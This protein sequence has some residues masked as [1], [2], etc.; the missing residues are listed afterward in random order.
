MTDTTNTNGA[1]SAAA[2]Q[3]L[4]P[5]QARQYELR[6]QIS[7]DTT[8]RAIVPRSLAEVQAFAS[9]M[10]NSSLVPTALRERAADVAMIIMAGAEIGIPPIKALGLYHVMEGVPKLSADGKAAVV[11]ASP[12]C[13]YFEP[14]EQSDTRVSWRGKRVGTK[15]KEIVVVWTKEMVS[16]AGLDRPT[17]NGNPSNHTKFPRAM[18]NARAKAELATLLLPEVVSGVMTYEEAMDQRH[19]AELENAAPPPT[20]KFAA[21]EHSRPTPLVPPTE[22]TQPPPKPEPAP[23]ASSSKAKAAAKPIDVAA[24]PSG[25]SAPSSPNTASTSSPTSSASSSSGSAPS[26]ADIERERALN[27]ARDNATEIERAR[28]EQFQERER[29]NERPDPTMEDRRPD[30]TTDAADPGAASHA[31]DAGDEFGDESSSAPP[32]KTI[33]AFEKGLADIVKR[34]AV[35]E[36]VAF[37]AEWVPWSRIEGPDGGKA[38]AYKMRDLFAKAATDLGVK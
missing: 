2:T 16:A 32:A 34:K 26:P 27:Q 37:K 38:H 29:G 8:P 9:M 31:S 36:L 13:E 20:S 28:Q 1:P 19:L 10:A 15:S 33:E 3:A 22:S 7:Q 35:G 25:S 6:E 11:S 21:P 30:A 24:A 23:R 17:R 14:V 4:T 5:Y 18:L 12:L